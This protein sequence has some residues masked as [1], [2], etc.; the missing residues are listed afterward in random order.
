MPN[1]PLGPSNTIS[2]AATNG[3]IRLRQTAELRAAGLGADEVHTPVATDLMQ[4][5]KPLVFME[6]SIDTSSGTGVGGSVLCWA[7]CG[8]D[9]AA[10]ILAGDTGDGK[11]LVG[12]DYRGLGD[13]S[14]AEHAFIGSGVV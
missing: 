6:G 12:G 7:T 3:R 8:L 4:V 10:A 2:L 14:T 13:V 1:D 9:G 11:I 5:M